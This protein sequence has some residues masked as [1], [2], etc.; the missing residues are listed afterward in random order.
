[1]RS[2]YQPL[3]SLYWRNGRTAPYVQ[4]VPVPPGAGDNIQPRRKPHM[5]E[6]LDLQALESV[7]ADDQ[8]LAVIQ[9]DGS[10]VSYNC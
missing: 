9:T 6:I 3:I 7:E 5:Q 2:A 10:G 1:M 4:N 8:S